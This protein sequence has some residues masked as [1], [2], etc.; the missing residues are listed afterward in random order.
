MITIIIPFAA[1]C[2]CVCVRAYFVEFPVTFVKSAPFGV[3]G[4]GVP[5]NVKMGLQFAKHCSEH[6]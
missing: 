5:V 2:V 6:V 4:W 3:S 1:L